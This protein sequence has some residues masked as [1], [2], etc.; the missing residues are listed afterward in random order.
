MAAI[1]DYI[2]RR[3]SWNIKHIVID[4][5]IIDFVEKVCYMEDWSFIS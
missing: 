5:V 4:F 3:G 1:L 2:T